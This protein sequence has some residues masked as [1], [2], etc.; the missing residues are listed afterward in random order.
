M[1]KKKKY[2]NFWVIIANPIAGAT[3]AGLAV[4][5]GFIVSI[6]SNEIKNSFPFFFSLDK[7]KYGSISYPALFFWLTF[8]I[9]LIVTALR[10]KI[11]DKEFDQ[12]QERL[13]NT[14]QSL[15]PHDFAMKYR[16]EYY[17][18]FVAVEKLNLL[19]LKMENETDICNDKED[20]STMEET[21]RTILDVYVSLAQI[22]DNPDS[23]INEDTVYRAN[24]MFYYDINTMPKSLESRLFNMNNFFVEKNIS[25]LKTTIDGVLVLED[26]KFTTTTITEE[27]LP[28]ED[29][30]PLCLPITFSELSSK[31]N[32]NLPGAPMAYIKKKT[33]WIL[34]TSQ[35]IDLCCKNDDFDGVTKKKI[36]DYYKSDTKGKS[37]ISMPLQLLINDDDFY[38]LGVI[39]IY[40]NKS[41]MLQNEIRAEQ[42]SAFLEPFNSLLCKAIVGY[43]EAS[44]LVESRS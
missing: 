33:Q 17:K 19:R 18:I 20:I 27:P 35:I 37:I 38:S 32:Q 12:K 4:I 3:I 24:M 44:E 9:F 10:Q 1:N 31:R 26:N 34:D 36:I 6:F 39:N 40:R 14:I 25:A 23:L 41:M 16:E 15:P 21:I 8:L 5:S 28:D 22:W 42:F 29:I 11:I 2:H 43:V 13:I 7:T 30:S